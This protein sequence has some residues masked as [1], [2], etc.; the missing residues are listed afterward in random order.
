MEDFRRGSVPEIVRKAEAFPL[1]YYPSGSRNSASRSS[2]MLIDETRKLNPWP[3]I[4]IDV[5]L[6]A[7]TYW[8]STRYPGPMPSAP[9]FACAFLAFAG[10]VIACVPFLVNHAHRQEAVLEERQNQIAALAQSTASSAEQLSIA[11]ASLHSIADSA[12][13]A[14]KHAEA[15]PQKMQEKI[16]EF[17]EQL[18]EVTV[19][20]NE[21]LSQEVNTLRAAETERMETMVT[22]VRKLSSEIARLE[23]ASRKNVTE[24]TETLAQFTASSEQAASGAATAIGTLRTDAETSLA[25]AQAAAVKSIE[26]TVARSLSE[27]EAR[28]AALTTQLATRLEQGPRPEAPRNHRPNPHPPVAPIAPVE[29]PATP[30]PAP[31]DV[32]ALPATTKLPVAAEAAAPQRDAVEAVSS[33]GGPDTDAAKASRKRAPRKPVDDGPTLGLDLPALDDEHDADEAPSSAL[34]TDGVTRLL[35]TAYIGI[36][37]KLFVRGE[38]PGLNREKGTPLQFV[39]IGKWRWEA[40]DAATPVRAR[41]YKNDEQECSIGEITVEPGHQTEVVAKF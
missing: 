24:L 29:S 28:F 34:S 12:S 4:A 20:E 3:F 14:A 16:H 41:L 30:A 33:P 6:L 7:A 37:N 8:I 13:R 11:A 18:N 31:A 22:T 2:L 5:L 38:G 39:S 21:A 19:S 40:A 27:I 35:V 10:A 17:K 32:R 15:L 36:G 25:S 9:L 26:A 1:R 23:A